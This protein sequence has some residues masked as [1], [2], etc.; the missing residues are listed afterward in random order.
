MQAERV[1]VPIVGGHYKGRSLNLNAQETVNLY[2]VLDREGGKYESAL[3][4]TPGCKVF[5]DI[6]V[7]AEVRNMIVVGDYLYAVAG[8]TMYKIAA[9][10]SKTPITGNLTTTTGH[11][12]MS[13]DDQN[14]MVVD[15]D[16]DGYTYDADAGGNLTAIADADFPVPSSL[17]W[18]DGYF[19]VSKKDS[20]QFF[21]S[22]SYDPTSWDALDYA[23]AESDPDDLKRV[24]MDHLN[25]IMFGKQTTE[26]WYNCGAS[27]F[28]FSRYG[29]VV[30]SHGIA[31][32]ASAAAGDNAVFWLTDKRIAVRADG[33]SP[34]NISTREI[35]YQWAQYSTVSDAR[36][37]CYSQEGH[38]FYVL[39][40]P[41]ANATWVYDCATK[42]WHQRR[43]YPFYPDGQE[44]RHRANCYAAFNGKHLLGDYEN[45]KIYEW[46]MDTYTD[47]A[48][49]IRRS[50]VTQVV[51]A[52]RQNL[53]FHTYE[54]EVEAGTS[55]L[56]GGDDW[57][58]STAYSL[59]D[60]VVPTTPNECV[61]E[62]TT[63][64]TTGATEPTWPI[65]PG[66]TVSDGTV[67]WTCQ[68]STPQMVLSWSN[69][70]GHTYGNE[71][72]RSLGAMGEY[73]KRAVWRRLGRARARNFRMSITSAAKVIILAAFADMEI[74]AS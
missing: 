39:T 16:I 57:Q 4:G 61:Y 60:R 8:N 67:V 14:L 53:F 52:N 62:C 19:I 56:P 13:H 30:V 48:E 74:G 23:T 44:R 65:T 58:A 51:H 43:S 2:P 55:D 41:T 40:F 3:V 38:T 11:V 32:P 26:P 29:N 46:D 10:A 59:A 27:N 37:F 54:V 20:G 33:F 18:Q 24:F 36:G 69:D 7:T 63:A 21:I 9:D 71:H 72:W 22:A 70:G 12:Y 25:L 31:A 66:A 15:P 34:V 17:T 49:P 73:S 42:L 64:G 35:E 50:R 28:P 6:G 1:R 5:C 47:N 45:G 68:G